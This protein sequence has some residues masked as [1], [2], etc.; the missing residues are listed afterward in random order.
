VQLGEIAIALGLPLEGDPKLDIDGLAGLDDAGEGELSF[1]TGP[2][3]REAVDGSRASAFLAPLDFDLGGRAC[4]RSAQPYL[5]F[6]RAIELL[7]PERATLPEVHPT[8]VIGDRTELGKDVSIGAYAVLGD[9][10]QIGD[11]SRIDPHVTI[12][13]DCTIGRD[14]TVHA[15]ARLHSRVRLGDRVVIHSGAVIGS[16]GF[17][18]AFGTDGTRVR[19]P[20]R[21]GVVIEDD[22]E[23]GANTTIDASQAAHAHDAQGRASTRIGR[24]VKIDNQVQ[25]AHG[26]EID[27]GSTLCAGAG[28]AGS[29]RIGKNV[30][31][32]GLSATSGNLRVADGTVVLGM[33]GVMS[34]TEPGAQLV[35][36]PVL[37]RRLFFRILA[38][39]KRLPELLKRVDRLERRLP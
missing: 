14:C 31:F 4:L 21:A 11:R 34:D 37:P 15:G 18:F 33:S 6:T 30:F 26:C 17:G 27:D 20:H 7:Y 16:Q 12:Y 5:D 23:I 24:G 29:S 22:A 35:G 38:A 10:V 19:V 25:V 9:D 39:S 13:P 1:V 8:A 2:R 36:V 32:G 28:I 3:Y